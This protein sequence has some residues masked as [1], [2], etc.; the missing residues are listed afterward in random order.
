MENE[1]GPIKISGTGYFLATFLRGA[2]VTRFYASGRDP[3]EDAIPHFVRYM[4]TALPWQHI[5][6]D[7]HVEGASGLS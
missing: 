2:C 7:E 3:V 6:R 4:F 5:N 1:T